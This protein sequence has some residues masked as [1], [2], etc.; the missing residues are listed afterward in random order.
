MAPSPL[1]NRPRT[2]KP[3]EEGFDGVLAARAGLPSWI[4]S[5]K[6]IPWMGKKSRKDDSRVSNRRWSNTSVR[7]DA[8]ELLVVL[9]TLG[10]VCVSSLL[11]SRSAPSVY[12]PF[13][14]FKNYPDKVLRDEAR[15][16]KEVYCPKDWKHF[17]PAQRPR[18]LLRRQILIRTYLK[19]FKLR[20]RSVRKIEEHARG[21][22]LQHLFRVL[23]E[24]PK[25]LLRKRKKWAFEEVFKEHIVARLSRNEK[26]NESL[27]LQLRKTIKSE[28]HN[29]ISKHIV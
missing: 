9:S 12:P 10:I 24:R 21:K 4:L 18:D 13:L 11:L 1:F 22:R 19:P 6:T 8:L 26:K 7:D 23:K 15:R 2:C 5:V 29:F 16:M 28:F 20:P 17:T 14:G 27:L 25:S 3:E